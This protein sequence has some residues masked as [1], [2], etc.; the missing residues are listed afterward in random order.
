MMIVN[1]NTNMQKVIQ[2][3]KDAT[4]VL[5]NNNNKN[6]TLKGVCKRLCPIF[7]TKQSDHAENKIMT[8]MDT[9]TFSIS[10]NPEQIAD[11]TGHPRNPDT[12]KCQTFKLK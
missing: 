11:N 9:E 6:E 2:M 10:L 1:N 8:T 4:R 3:L 12:L 5:N 7:A